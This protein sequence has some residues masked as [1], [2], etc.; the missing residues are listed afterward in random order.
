MNDMSNAGNDEFVIQLNIA[1]KVYKLRCKRSEEVVARKAARQI[2]DKILQYRRTFSGPDLDL[3]D[4]L[5]MVAFQLSMTNLVLENKDDV[6]PVFKKLEDLT[7]E[8][9]TYLKQDK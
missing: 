8:I 4:L 1:D 2:N 9:E 5:A 3:K 7:L 6:S